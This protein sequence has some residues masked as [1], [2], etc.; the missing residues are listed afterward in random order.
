[1]LWRGANVEEM[2]NWY[3]SLHLRFLALFCSRYTTQHNT[4][5]ELLHDAARSLLVVAMQL[6][7]HVIVR[8]SVTSA[9]IEARHV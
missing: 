6:L 1:M 9:R 7:Q 4:V 5:S 8:C 3:Y 2:G